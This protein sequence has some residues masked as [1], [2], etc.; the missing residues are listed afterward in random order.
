MAAPWAFRSPRTFHAC[1]VVLGH[2]NPVCYETPFSWIMAVRC[3]K[4]A[5]CVWSGLQTLT[6]NV[7]PIVSASR[8]GVNESWATMV[9]GNGHLGGKKTLQVCQSVFL[10]FRKLGWIPPVIYVNEP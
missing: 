6:P 1:F 8:A 5:A 10:T 2:H 4:T 3:E 7:H 9:T